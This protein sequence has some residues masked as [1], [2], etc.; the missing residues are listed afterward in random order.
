MQA[1]LGCRLEKP[2]VGGR[3][4]CV[5]HDPLR[6]EVT[7][8]KTATTDIAEQGLAERT[9]RRR[10]IEL[11]RARAALLNRKD[12]AMMELYLEGHTSCR[13]IARLL[14]QSETSIARRIKKLI[15]RLSDD[16]YAICRLHRAC[17]TLGELDIAKD[18][19]LLGLPMAEIARRRGLS[20]YRV[21]AAARSI[22][23]KAKALARGAAHHSNGAQEG[24]SP[25]W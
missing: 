4:E 5:D 14:G 22:R 16:T 15:Q 17:F 9:A 7:R 11:L 2:N 18:H 19:F 12:K 20:Y 3:R 21:R 25:T 24:G 10:R 8:M 13:R 23:R 1:R 6:V